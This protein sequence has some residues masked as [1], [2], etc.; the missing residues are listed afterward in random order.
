MKQTSGERADLLP[1]ESIA[2]NRDAASATF[3]AT[4]EWSTLWPVTLHQLESFSTVL[5]PLGYCKSRRGLIVRGPI[6]NI[7][8]I[9]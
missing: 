9:G 7:V 2:S 1:F 4:I 3:Q 5:H 6:E 8:R